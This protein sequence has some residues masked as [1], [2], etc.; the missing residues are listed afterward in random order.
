MQ[1]GKEKQSICFTAS[2]VNSTHTEYS[3][4][5]TGA[6]TDTFSSNYARSGCTNLVP[7]CDS[8]PF[9]HLPNGKWCKCNGTSKEDFLLSTP[10]PFLERLRREHIAFV[11]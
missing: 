2:C 3:K 9:D 5:V 4:S 7:S 8:L 6:L 1:K 10:Y 11:C